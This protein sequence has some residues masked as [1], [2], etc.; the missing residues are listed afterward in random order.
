MVDRLDSA[1]AIDLF[2]G[3][4]GLTHGLL[5]SGIPV[6]A[7]VD[8]DSTCEYGYEKNNKEASFIAGD[9]TDSLLL[10]SLKKR[11]TPKARR[12]LVGCAP[13]Q[14]FSTH[15]QKDIFRDKDKK[16]TLIES[17]LEAA[18]FLKPHVISMEN[19]AQ[20]AKQDIFK[21]F[22]ATLE[23]DLKYKVWYDVVNCLDYGLPQTRKRL[24]LLA[25]KL[26]NIELEQ[27][28]YYQKK[29]KTV[30]QVI[31]KLDPIPAGNISSKD[32]LH[33][34]R[35]LS[36][37]NLRR[38]RQSKPG[39]TW[40]DWD[41]GLRAP[42]HRKKTGESY[43]SVY[44]RMEWD[45]PSPTITTQ[46]HS[47]GTGRFGHP[48]QDRALSLREGALLQGFP[49]S[50]SFFDPKLPDKKISME[51]IGIHIG[52]AVPVTLA[53]VIGRTIYNHLKNVDQKAKSA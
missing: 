28:T 15:T 22:V 31:G 18:V 10:K 23:Q 44:A 6:A 20:L 16:W 36:E 9:V 17:F 45:A 13:C 24:V 25:S 26:G 5:K 39:G 29:P 3:V 4:G 14:P 11:Y 47:F 30:R 27:G 2:C 37:I 53:K 32:R 21:K 1:V 34:A 8:L 38:I 35:N 50:Y 41:E 40:R 7:G 48:E 49:K 12:I 52:N 46:F 33:K 43:S 51:R 42:C 19:V